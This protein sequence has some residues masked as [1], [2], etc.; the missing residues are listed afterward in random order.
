[1][2]AYTS[3]DNGTDLDTLAL[4]TRQTGSTVLSNGLRLLST[5]CVS[6]EVTVLHIDSLQGCLKYYWALSV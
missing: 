4:H 2:T 5:D 6:G 3:E 1:M